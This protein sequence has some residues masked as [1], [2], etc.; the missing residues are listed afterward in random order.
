MVPLAP[1]PHTL[2]GTGPH[3]VIAVHG[4]FADRRAYD[5]ILPDLDRETFSYAFVDLRG[6]GEAMH[7]TG[8]HSTAEGG[9]DVLALADALG[10]DRFSLVG[11]SMGACVAQRV[12]AAAP[13]RVR[14]LVGLNP[15]PAGGF[16]MPPQQWELFSGAAEFP[17]NRRT[18]IDI[19]T[20]G[21]RP[22]AWL[23]RMVAQSQACSDAKAFRA[24][25][26]SWA[27]EDFHEAIEGAGLPVRVV[28]GELD[29]ALGAEVMRATWLRW[30]RDAEL[31]VLPAAG[32][33]PMEETPLQL[34]TA[35][36]D[37]LRA[38]EPEPESAQ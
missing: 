33:Y 9:A 18:I 32:H 38:D 5:R 12:L 6:Y 17:G 19:T 11:H 2:I 37:F 30:Y 13:A 35:V 28:V 36:E 23:D 25:L 1:L 34:V 16:P 3:R 26:D 20:G 8:A 31:V 22:A 24:W 29:P 15:V 7:R 27:G 21:V 10:W 14:R 4:W